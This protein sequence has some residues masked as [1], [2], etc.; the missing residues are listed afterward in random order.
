MLRIGL[1]GG[2]GCGKSLAAELF[3]AHGAVVIDA[4]IAARRVVEPG[5]EALAE[6]AAAFGPKCI[7]SD[8]SLDRAVLREQVFSDEPSRRHLE[9]ILHPRIR[10]WMLAE[11][12]KHRDVPY[13]IFVVPL[14]VESGWQALVDRVLVIDC[15]EG[16]Q[17]LRVG[18]RDGLST[19]QIGAIIDSQVPRQ[20][21]LAAADDICHNDGS[22]A[23][24]EIQVEQ[25]HQH[26]LKL[27]ATL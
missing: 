3:A 5:S 10:S 15:E 2:I 11:A 23:E 4:D 25:L 24:L 12:E 9:A 14:L 17:Y 20:Q 6:I 21:R 19:A 8:G 26:Y 27:A 22:T 16:H 13:L 7:S 1:T 18:T